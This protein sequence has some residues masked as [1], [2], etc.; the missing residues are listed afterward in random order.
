M[1]RTIAR[2]LESRLCVCARECQLPN[3]NFAPKLRR[4]HGAPQCLSRVSPPA[5]DA[6]L[7]RPSEFVVAAAREEEGAGGGGGVDHRRRTRH[8]PSPG[9][10]VCQ[11]GGQK[12]TTALTCCCSV[13]VHG[14][15][16]MFV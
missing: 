2:P 12:G 15:L 13:F 16:Q 7:C 5:S 11:A 1:K 3:A 14:S 9:Q 10:G 6:L 4:R 8:R